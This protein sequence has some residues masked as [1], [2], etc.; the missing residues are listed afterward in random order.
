MVEIFFPMVPFTLKRLPMTFPDIFPE[1]RKELLCLRRK[2][3]S[4]DYITDS[5]SALS[6]VCIFSVLSEIVLVKKLLL[7]WSCGRIH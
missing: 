5:L 7:H 3:S 1:I 2:H 6:I 4:L